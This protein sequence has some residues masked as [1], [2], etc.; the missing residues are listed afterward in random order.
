MLNTNADTIASTLAS[1]LAQLYEVELHFC[2]EKDGVLADV[3]DESSVIP[4]IT[5]GQ[6]R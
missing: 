1:A 3:N 6:Y 2:F 5:P 4:Q